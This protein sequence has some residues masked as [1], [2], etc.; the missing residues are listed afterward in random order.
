LLQKQNLG[1]DNINRRKST[2]DQP[3]RK[4]YRQAI[5]AREGELASPMAET[6]NWSPLCVC[7]RAH[8]Y[9]NKK[10]R[11]RISIREWSRAWEALEG[12]KREGMS[13]YFD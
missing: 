9:N 10:K 6:P 13:L 2:Q 8:V 7:V 3:Q 12:G 1:N 4:N 5:T 11:K